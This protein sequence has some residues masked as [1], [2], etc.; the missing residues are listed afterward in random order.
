V[1]A[2]T[3]CGGAYACTGAA[4][5]C[6]TSCTS[7]TQ[8]TSSGTCNGFYDGFEVSLG[9]WVLGGT[10]TTEIV[11][12]NNQVYAGSWALGGKYSNS[13]NE[14]IKVN[15][16]FDNSTNT[17]HA[18]FQAWWDSESGYDWIALQA[19]TDDFAS[20]NTTIWGN[21]SGWSSGWNAIDVALPPGA[22]ISLRF[23][24]HSDGSLSYTSGNFG[25]FWID[26]FSVVG[27]CV[28]K[29]GNFADP[30][31][32]ICTPCGNGGA[33]YAC[34][35]GQY[36]NGTACTGSG[37][38]DTQTCQTCGNG[39]ASYNCGGDYKAGTAC[40]GT[41]TSDTQTCSQCSSRKCVSV[42]SN[43]TPGAPASCISSTGVTAD[44][45]DCYVPPTL[46][47]PVGGTCSLGA[48]NAA[49]TR[50]WCTRNDQCASGVCANW[51]SCT[52]QGDGPNQ[53]VTGAVGQATDNCVAKTPWTDVCAGTCAV[54]ATSSGGTC[55]CNNDNQCANGVCVD[56]GQCAAGA[57]SSTTASDQGTDGCSK[58][59]VRPTC[60]NDSGFTCGSISGAGCY[61]TGTETDCHCK[62]D[63]QC[64]TG[65][66]CLPAPANPTCTGT[67]TGTGTANKFGCTPTSTSVTSWVDIATIV[68]VA[69]TYS[70]AAPAVCD[71]S[72]NFCWCTDDTQ[73]PSGACVDQSNHCPDP[74]KC[75][76]DAS[77][78]V[79]AASCEGAT[80]ATCSNDANCGSSGSN[81]EFCSGAGSGL[82]LCTHTCDASH[83]CP[84]GETC[85]AGRCTGCTKNSQCPD[86]TYTG[87]CDG[88]ATMT[89]GKCCTPHSPAIACTTDAQCGSGKKCDTVNTHTCWD[90]PNNLSQ[91]LFPEN[92]ANT[93]MSD[94][95]KALEFMFFDLT[96][97]VTPDTGTPGTP[98]IT[99]SPV[100]FPLDFTGSCPTGYLVK[101]RELDYQATFPTAVGSSIV[102]AA[103]T[104]TAGNLASYLPQPTPLALVTATTNTALPNN[105]V[106]LLDTSP[107]GTGKFTV[108]GI[109]S[110]TGLR[111]TVTMNPSTD[112][113]AS[114]TLLSWKVVYDCAAAE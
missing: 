34:A 74:S 80:P 59:T 73:C 50:C 114:P 31:T 40:T 26:E 16:T 96:S 109:A 46:P 35:T 75:T 9:N 69:S 113:H 65:F 10:H 79:D 111:L 84:G 38:S 102:F 17:L 24:V 91:A 33:T 32:G 11:R 1:A 12:D 94:Q 64:G 5:T 87:Y 76:G 21:I 71:P 47:V 106:V 18:T 23:F 45:N 48:K 60:Y 61:N 55:K 42:S 4:S 8:C 54:W 58:T 95:E 85:V 22:S 68:P 15:R 43:C 66:F 112:Q 36:K 29:P 7:D 20:N 108:A 104:G 77:K 57:C 100:T 19:S 88:G 67:C 44:D 39:G 49:G 78:G 30:G 62:S 56:T 72:H 93:D 86:R 63:S 107:G 82:G 27:K 37:T 14:W 41:G 89:I 25:G 101:W 70:C 6:P 83:P 103:Q 53:C 13:E 90:C 28:C 97:C 99:L 2:G 51:G 52:S 92:C 105:D 98:A 110:G 3:G 81:V